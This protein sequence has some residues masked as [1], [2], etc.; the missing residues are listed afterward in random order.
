METYCKVYEKCDCPSKLRS[1]KICF[2][3]IQ[4]NDLEPKLKIFED[5]LGRVR[6]LA[7]CMM[8]KVPGDQ[9]CALEIPSGIVNTL[10]AT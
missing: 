2:P 8:T 4:L 7:Q 6:N 10:V 9:S 1:H 5:S 3:F